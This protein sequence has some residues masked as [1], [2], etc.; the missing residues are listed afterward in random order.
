MTCRIG[1]VDLIISL[2]IGLTINDS[3]SGDFGLSFNPFGWVKINLILLKKVLNI[4]YPTGIPFWGIHVFRD[5]G[6]LSDLSPFLIYSLFYCLSFA[7]CFVIFN[8]PSFV[9]YAL[10]VLV[11]FH[12]CWESLFIYKYILFKLFFLI[13]KLAFSL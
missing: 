5:L 2:Q 3:G 7:L 11:F 12:V 10:S 6:F 9:Y 4:F 13:L 8:L 1:W